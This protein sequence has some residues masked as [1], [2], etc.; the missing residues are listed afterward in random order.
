MNTFLQIQS[1]QYLKFCLFFIVLIRLSSSPCSAQIAE[2]EGTVRSSANAPSFILFDTS[3]GQNRTEGAL[4]SV[5]NSSN[6]ILLESHKGDLRLRTGSSSTVLPIDRM[7]IS[8]ENGN[9]GI[10]TRFPAAKLDIVGTT[11]STS[12]LPEFQL[13]DNASGENRIEGRLRESANN[14]ILQSLIG[15][16]NLNTNDKMNFTGS[17]NDGSLFFIEN[18]NT[19][20]GADLLALKVGRTSNPT[21]SNNFITFFRGDDIATG[22]IEGNGAGGVLYGTTGSDF[23]ESLPLSSREIKIEK[24]DV[25]GVYNGKISHNTLKATDVMVITD[26]PAVLGN[27]QVES[28]EGFE[29]V[30]FIGQV[31]VK[32]VGK[33]N[34]G[35]WIIPSG[36]HDGIARAVNTQELAITD[37][38]IGRSWDSNQTESIKKVTVAVGLDKSEGLKS[39]ISKMSKQIT[40]LEKKIIK[41]ENK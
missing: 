41:L 39:L 7:T 12:G 15:D 38:I 33:V 16:L 2:F 26:R 22:R 20:T 14:I 9:V 8:G 29:N 35:D 27:Q 36:N 21:G 30:S 19:S 1:F 11:R 23:A 37:R 13:F 40:D 6:D 25:V 10:G 28:T 24:G 17:K 5:G 3:N 32:V 34:V 31:P 4:R 18:T